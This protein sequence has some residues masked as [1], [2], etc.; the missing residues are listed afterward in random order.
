MA[1]IGVVYGGPGSGSTAYSMICIG[2]TRG[3]LKIINTGNS[4][5][6]VSS[7][8]VGLVKGTAG[9]PLAP[10]ERFERQATT[11][12]EEA[13]HLYSVCPTPTGG[14]VDVETVAVAA[15]SPVTAKVEGF[16]ERAWDW[17]GV[18]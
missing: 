15:P 17:L 8:P 5:V 2:Q 14:E 13:Q 9:F 3:D 16:F 10:G 18:K 1:R 4:M 11:A 6:L 12:T 7:D